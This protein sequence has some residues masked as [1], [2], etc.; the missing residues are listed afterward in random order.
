MY[1]SE[2]FDILFFVK[3]LSIVIQASELANLSP[4]FCINW[5]RISCQSDS[6]AQQNISCSSLLL[7]QI[8]TYL[9]LS[10]PIDPSLS[11]H[12]SKPQLINIFWCN[13][14]SYF[15]PSHPCSFHVICPCCEC[16]Q[17]PL[18]VCF[19]KLNMVVTFWGCR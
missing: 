3:F 6:Q 19:T 7:S 10:P 9:E 12:T 5:I 16:S 13:F 15:D 17:I 2:L 18:K 11:F 4:F 8:G 14:W 1:L